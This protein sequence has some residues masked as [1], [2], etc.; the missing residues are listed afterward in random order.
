MSGLAS[1]STYENGRTT[2][3]EGD[4]NIAGEFLY[5]NSIYEFDRLTCKIWGKNSGENYYSENDTIT[6]LD[7][8]YSSGTFN[9]WNE[10]NNIFYKKLF[11]LKLGSDTSQ[12]ALYALSFNALKLYQY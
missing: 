1:A 3:F 2:S 8:T 6:D 9:G 4:I 12:I 7:I 11:K 10:R 5:L